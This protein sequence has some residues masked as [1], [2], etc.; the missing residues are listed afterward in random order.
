VLLG[1]LVITGIGQTLLYALLP[2]ASRP[3]GLTE[4]QA[5]AVYALSALFWSGFSPFWG[6]ASDRG[7]GVW[8]LCLGMIGQASSNLAVG[9]VLVAAL[10]GALPHLWV[11]PLLMILRGINGVLGSAVLPAAQ[12]IALRSAPH[13]PRIAIVGTVATCWNIGSMSGPSFASALIVFGSGAPLFVSAAIAVLAAGIMLNRPAAQGAARAPLPPRPGAS[14]LVRARIW[15]FMAMSL[16][17]NTASNIV[18]QVTAYFVLDRLGLSASAVPHVVGTALTLVAA[19]SVAAQTLA[20]RLR[21]SASALMTGGALAVVLAA[22]A[23]LAMP[24]TWVLL[25]ALS[26]AGMGLG[27]G[28]LGISTAASLMM[29]PSQQGAV[30]GTLASASS[31]GAILSAG[32]MLSYRH[33]AD[34]PYA[35]VAL[36]C[37]G[38]AIASRLAP[39]PRHG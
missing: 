20:I 9:V 7:H 11:F 14:R 8:V 39:R 32:V 24:V 34:G 28:S 4:S 2:L 12:G 19:S 15:P 10:R 38:V 27:V 6:R 13:K 35:M 31:L 16:A 22:C 26:L 36:L 5:S 17:L 25:P 3:L 37:L 29:R 18:A 21:P 1:S 23:I 33:W 30:A